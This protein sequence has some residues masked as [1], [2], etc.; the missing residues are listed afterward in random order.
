MDE[1]AKLRLPP[2]SHPSVVLLAGFRGRSLGVHA[3]RWHSDSER[4]EE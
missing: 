2:P 1:H 4:N 3:Q